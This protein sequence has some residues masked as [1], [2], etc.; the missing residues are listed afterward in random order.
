MDNVFNKKQA[1]YGMYMIIKDGRR[2]FAKDKDYFISSIIP[3]VKPGYT[4]CGTG[5]TTF[6]SYAIL[7]KRGVMVSGGMVNERVA[8]DT[9][10]DDAAGLMVCG[11]LSDIDDLMVVDQII[12]YNPSYKDFG[13]T[14]P[15][16]AGNPGMVFVASNFL[17][18][19]QEKTY[20][21]SGLNTSLVK[22][23]SDLPSSFVI[24][25]TFL[26]KIVPDS[27][28]SIYSNKF[29][30]CYADGQPIS[31]QI[32]A[33]TNTIP[34]LF[35]KHEKICKLPYSSVINV[36]SDDESGDAILEIR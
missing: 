18:D 21:I 27:Y 30:L 9:S 2:V 7:D 11:K 17:F 22:G 35:D 23:Y 24:Y 10:S 12:N 4:I 13:G 31:K 20:K 33:Y 3:T 29:R 19:L 28:V 25:I 14:Y 36:S 16:S 8:I 32:D 5:G 6:V 15:E 34:I 26:T 1:S